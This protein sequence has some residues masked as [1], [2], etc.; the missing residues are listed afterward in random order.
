MR[1]RLAPEVPSHPA[2]AGR[3]TVSQMDPDA[4]ISA[5]FGAIH[6]I[7]EWHRSRSTLGVPRRVGR[8]DGAAQ[9]GDIRESDAPVDGRTHR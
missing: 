1:T 9:P 5:S 6:P 7:V 2:Q 8:A 3:T 4:S